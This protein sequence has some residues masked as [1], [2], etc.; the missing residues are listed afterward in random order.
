M[1]SILTMKNVKNLEWKEIYEY[2]E[3]AGQPLEENAISMGK[4]LSKYD[5]LIERAYK[6]VLNKVTN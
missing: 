6:D 4:K 2:F 3:S 5:S 1:D